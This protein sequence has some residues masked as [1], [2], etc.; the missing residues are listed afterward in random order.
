MTRGN[1]PAWRA[2]TPADFVC[3]GVHGHAV[4]HVFIH[5]LARILKHPQLKV[6][7]G[8]LRSEQ[9]VRAVQSRCV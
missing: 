7:T 4:Q 6:E 2:P 5:G 3:Q 1:L 8:G 9:P